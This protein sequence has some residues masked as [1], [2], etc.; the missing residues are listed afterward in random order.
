MW[1]GTALTVLVT[2]LSTA[3]PETRLFAH[4]LISAIVLTGISPLLGELIRVPVT[5]HDAGFVFQIICIPAPGFGDLRSRYCCLV[6]L[7]VTSLCCGAG[8]VAVKGN[9][10]CHGLDSTDAGGGWALS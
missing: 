7:S 9:D 3:Q 8:L 4:V 10:H 1:A 5:L 2:P 6:Q